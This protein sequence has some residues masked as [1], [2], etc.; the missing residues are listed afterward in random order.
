MLPTSSF[1]RIHHGHIVKT[2]STSANYKGRN[3]SVIMQAGRELKI[4]A[5]RKNEF[6][7]CI[8]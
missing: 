8:F 7:V 5:R 1:F 3:G 2:L 6:D 4:A